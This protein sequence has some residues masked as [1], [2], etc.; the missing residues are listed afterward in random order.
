MRITTLSAQLAIPQLVKPVTLVTQ[1]L[2]PHAHHATVSFHL[3]KIALQRFVF[4]AK[5]DSI[6]RLMSANLAYQSIIHLALNVMK[7]NALPANLDI[8]SI[9]LHL[10][11][12]QLFAEMDCGSMPKK[13]V[14]MVILTITMA[15]IL[16]AE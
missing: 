16:D 14:M 2:E 7:L 10:Y 3:V 8:S 11:V 13:P 1:L 5:L 12:M 4:N 15:A 9:K 6:Y